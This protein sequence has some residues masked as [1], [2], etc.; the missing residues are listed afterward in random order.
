MSMAFASKCG[1]FGASLG[2]KGPSWVRFEADL[3]RTRPSLT[4]SD[5]KLARIGPDSVEIAQIWQTSGQIWSSSGQI[6][7][8]W[9][10]AGTGLAALRTPDLTSVD[11]AP[12]KWSLSQG[13]LPH[14]SLRPV[15]QWFNPAA[16]PAAF[17][18]GRPTLQLYICACGRAWRPARPCVAAQAPLVV[19][20]SVR[21][22]WSS[23]HRRGVLVILRTA[24]RS[25][26]AATLQSM[27]ITIMASPR[28]RACHD[29]EPD[30]ARF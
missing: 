27:R 4:K 24:P 2:R 17:A 6:R 30:S 8:K 19:T 10:G 29:V 1:P 20:H 16:T 28:P 21:R 7:P 14:A 13:V 25:R 26:S 22:P 23:G 18:A 9:P 11:I 12:T 3:S 15:L 5:A